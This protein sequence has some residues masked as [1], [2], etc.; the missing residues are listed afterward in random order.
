MQKGIIIVLLL[1]FFYAPDFAQ[2]SKMEAKIDPAFRSLITKQR[3]KDSSA[4]KNCSSCPKVKAA[5]GK[6][7]KNAPAEKKYECI[8]YTK[9]AKALHN[10]GITINSEL[11][12]FV[13]AFVTL[14]QIEQLSSMP[15]VTYIEAPK[16]NVLH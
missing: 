9:N 1:I 5:K 13:T 14:Q 11:P 12:T 8:I 7:S 15:E 10:R 16:T 3:A 6:V 4:S 2:N